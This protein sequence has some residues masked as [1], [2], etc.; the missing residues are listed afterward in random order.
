MSWQKLV[1][2][3][4]WYFVSLMRWRCL[5][6][7]CLS[8]GTENPPLLGRVFGRVLFADFN[9]GA[10]A[11]GGSPKR[12]ISSGF[13]PPKG[14]APTADFRIKYALRHSQSLFWTLPRMN[15][16]S[17][18]SLGLRR[19]YC[20]LRIYFVRKSKNPIKYVFTRV[21]VCGI[22]TLTEYQNEEAILWI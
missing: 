21:A 6:T 20:T 4:T 16:R 7:S 12:N 19:V 3:W 17:L 5:S 8:S 14:A 11:L 2:L 15:E 10:A 22:L 18:K 9:V 13:G 1:R